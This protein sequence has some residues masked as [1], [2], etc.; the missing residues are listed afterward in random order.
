MDQSW[1]WIIYQNTRII[2]IFVFEKV[3]HQLGLETY[4]GTSSQDPALLRCKYFWLDRESL[5]YVLIEIYR[6]YIRLDIRSKDC[7]TVIKYHHNRTT[8]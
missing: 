8:W 3:S 5:I 6:I 4:N 2:Y 1:I 7:N